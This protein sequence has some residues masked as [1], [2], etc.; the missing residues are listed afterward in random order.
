[1][2]FV[3]VHGAWH[4]GWC[5]HDVAQ[6]LRADGHQV[7][8]PT[9]TGL[10]ER[11]HLLDESVGLSTFIDDICAVIKC[12]ELDDVVLVGHHFAG[13]VISGVADRKKE[14]IRRL[15]YLD[16]LIVQNGES[17]L[18]ILP[19]S[20][21]ADRGQAMDPEGLRMKAPEPDKLGVFEPQ[22]AE[23]IKR[24]LTPHPLKSYNDTVRLKHP[25]GNGLPKTY[26]ACTNPWFLPLAGARSWVKQQ[27]DWDWREIATGHSAM[28][29]SP[30]A[31]AALLQDIAL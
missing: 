9:L 7:F 13:L 23:W 29:V 28:V 4:G 22:Q 3:L 27:E 12:E 20:V 24:R 5:W 26:I 1:M 14:R 30:Y 31:L 6:H 11:A 10:G 21:R 18:S 2:N 16:A 17:G 15:V 19:P 8:T 25:V